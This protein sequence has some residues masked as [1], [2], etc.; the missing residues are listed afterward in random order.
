M[1]SILALKL[2]IIW[3]TGFNN[4]HIILITLSIAG[5]IILGNGIPNL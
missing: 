1:E 5:K 4:L 3:N 2:P